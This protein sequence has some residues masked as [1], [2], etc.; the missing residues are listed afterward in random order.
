MSDE[1]LEETQRTRLK[2]LH[3]RGRFDRKTIA[4][5]LQGCAGNVRARKLRVIEI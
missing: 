4:M 1:T 2:R 3:E 5:F